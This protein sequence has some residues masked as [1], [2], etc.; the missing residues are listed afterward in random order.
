MRTQTISAICL[1]LAGLAIGFFLSTGRTAPSPEGDLKPREKVVVAGM[2]MEVDLRI[3]N[4]PLGSRIEWH[5]DSGIFNPE[6]TETDLKST[7]TA[8]ARQGRVKLWV[9]LVA[10]EHIYKDVASTYLDVSRPSQGAVIDQPSSSP[11]P[12]AAVVT[13]S[14]LSNRLA[15]R[16]ITI[17]PFDSK[18][19]PTTSADIEGEVDGLKETEQE[20]GE[21]RIVLYAK[22]DSTWWVQP[23]AAAPYTLLDRH[24]R[25]FSWTHTGTNY[26]ALLV[27]KGYVAPEA[28]DGELPEGPAILARKEVPGK[29][30]EKNQ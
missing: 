9:E 17:P 28:I 5:A 30:K 18:G 6:V 15:I 26:A 1:L 12:A 14:P 20:T 7:F 10:G 16:F 21:F 3:R 2:N 19:G 22:T 27:R 4:R 29:R 23:L 25:F 24:G 13:E 8:P 11:A